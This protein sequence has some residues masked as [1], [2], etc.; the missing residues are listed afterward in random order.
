MEH[1]VE[2]HLGG[3]YVSSLDEEIITK[4][5]EECGDSDWIILSWEEGQMM[6]ALSDY[7][8]KPVTTRKVI[9]DEL[10]SG[11]T[12]PEAINNILYYY[13]NDKYLINYLFNEKIIDEE[14]KNKLM[15]INLQTRKSMISLVCEI[16][17]KKV[18]KKSLRK[19]D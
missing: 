6:E 3:Y 16:Y 13:D 10:K 2:S 7:F 17:P 8:S 11:I 9:E 19:E 14:D 18:K 4:Y 12:K 5:C 1:L 15:K